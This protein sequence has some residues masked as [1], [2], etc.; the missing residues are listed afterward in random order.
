VAASAQAESLIQRGI[1]L[2]RQNR[3][4]EALAEFTKAEEVWPSAKAKAQIALA[5]MALGR[6]ESAEQ[7]LEQT[8]S[9]ASG[10]AWVNEHRA[11]LNE[12][13]DKIRRHLGTLNVSGQPRGA[14][15]QINGA[16]VCSIPCSVHVQAGDVAVRAANPGFVP[17]LRTIAVEAGQIAT[18]EF[19]LVPVSSGQEPTPDNVSI[20]RD[21]TDSSV[22]R[23]GSSGEVGSS[24]WPWVAAAGSVVGLTIGVIEAVRWSN[25]AAD[26]NARRDANG[27]ALCGTDDPGA[28]DKACTDLL[29]E[30]R[31]ARLF[32]IGG[33]ALGVGLGITSAILFSTERSRDRGQQAISC[34][35]AGLTATV[36][37][38]A[39]F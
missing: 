4:A 30:G 13:L 14:S 33:F 36:V 32:A 8:L 15:V 3:D 34:G 28:G 38:A 37:C 16:V 20:N 21:R 27:N 17:I 25:R 29:D 5:E 2:R 12:A 26:F 11:T 31:Q 39:T 7:K 22:N 9:G 1:E 24:P 19:N 6:F 23:N 18:E 10:D 35:P